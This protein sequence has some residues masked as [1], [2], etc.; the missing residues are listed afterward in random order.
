L[1]ALRGTRPHEREHAFERMIR[2]PSGPW[3]FSASPIRRSPTGRPRPCRSGTRPPRGKGTGTDGPRGIQRE[4]GGIRHF[5]EVVGPGSAVN[6]GDAR[7]IRSGRTGGIL[8]SLVQIHVDMGPHG[9]DH[10]TVPRRPRTLFTFSPFRRL[11]GADPHQYLPPQKPHEGPAPEDG[12][13]PA[14]SRPRGDRRHERPG[15]S[16]TSNIFSNQDQILAPPSSP[17]AAFQYGGRFLFFPL[18]VSPG[19]LSYFPSSFLLGF[20]FFFWVVKYPSRP[21][22]PSGDLCDR[23]FVTRWN[24]FI[25]PEAPCFSHRDGAKRTMTVPDVRGTRP[26]TIPAEPAQS[27]R[28]DTSTASDSFQIAPAQNGEPV[29]TLHTHP[30]LSDAGLD[31]R[32]LR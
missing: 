1:P 32:D 8:P 21:A 20:D 9:V 3:R 10:N 11:E 17:T 28:A 12:V 14:R 16:P 26:R 22:P 19:F 29:S 23:V 25:W 5:G 18:S 7:G 6:A 13:R 15:G 4:T 24:Q 30:P 2:C 27:H 31:N